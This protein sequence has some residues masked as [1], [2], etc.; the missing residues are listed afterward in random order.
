MCDSHLS[1]KERHIFNTT[2]SSIYY[3][4]TMY[5]RNGRH[6]LQ[7]TIYFSV[8][9]ILIWN[10]SIYLSYILLHDTGIF[11]HLLEQ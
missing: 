4:Y 2:T 3:Y 10:R 1:M 6:V 11:V 5:E 9:N 7:M 8:L